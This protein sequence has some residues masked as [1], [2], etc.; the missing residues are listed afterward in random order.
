MNRLKTKYANRKRKYLFIRYVY[1]KNTI[2]K[3]FIK[4]KQI[5]YNKYQPR[6]FVFLHFFLH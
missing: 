1:H 4:K 6:Q 3:Y 2:H 5:I